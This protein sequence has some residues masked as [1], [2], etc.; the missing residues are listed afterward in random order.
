MVQI[1]SVVDHVHA[2]AIDIEQS[3][4]F[5][6]RTTALTSLRGSGRFLINV[7]AEDQVAALTAKI[8]ETKEVANY[9]WLLKRAEQLLPVTV[10]K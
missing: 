8:Q 9:A 4:D 7:L 2:R 3:L 1:D 10:R 6:T 5:T